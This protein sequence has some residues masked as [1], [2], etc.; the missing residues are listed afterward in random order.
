MLSWTPRRDQ[1]SSSRLYKRDSH[2]SAALH[3]LF[4]LLRHRCFAADGGHVWGWLDFSHCICHRSLIFP[5]RRERHSSY[6]PI[7]GMFARRTQECGTCTRPLHQSKFATLCIKL[8]LLYARASPATHKHMP[9]Y[10]SAFLAISLFAGAT[11]HDSMRLRGERCANSI[12]LSSL[13]KLFVCL[14]AAHIT[15]NFLCAFYFG[16]SVLED[17]T[18]K[19]KNLRQCRANDQIACGNS[20]PVRHIA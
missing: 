2:S 7:F 19:A 10:L 20:P 12:F 9:S 14:L 5:V 6:Y 18:S 8:H 15:K 3:A 4:C 11:E 17:L 1:T 16:L 13:L